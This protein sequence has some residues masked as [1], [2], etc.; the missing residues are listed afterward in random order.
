MTEPGPGAVMTRPRR[1][2]NAA[3]MSPTL[4]FVPRNLMWSTPS[5]VTTADGVSTVNFA[6]ETEPPVAVIY[7]TATRSEPAGTSYG[8]SVQFNE[9]VTGFAVGDIAVGFQAVV[10]FAREVLRK[11][12]GREAVERAFPRA[13]NGATGDDGKGNPA[14]GCDHHA[15]QLSGGHRQRCTDTQLV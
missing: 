1:W 14:G 9:P 11:G 15:D 5:M 4:P 12:D 8:I 13:A 2:P 10:D 7:A 3:G 6:A